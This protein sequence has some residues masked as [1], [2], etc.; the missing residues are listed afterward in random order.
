[1]KIEIQP[2]I[3]AEESIKKADVV[4][5]SVEKTTAADYAFEKI[6]GLVPSRDR[7]V[8]RRVSGND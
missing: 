7:L 2:G 8:R 1:M 3:F 6:S 4:P 5:G